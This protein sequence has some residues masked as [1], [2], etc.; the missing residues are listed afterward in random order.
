MVICVGICLQFDVS[1]TFNT[2]HSAHEKR[3]VGVKITGAYGLS[4]SVVSDIIAGLHPQS[5]RH[6][7]RK[8]SARGL[9]ALRPSQ[10]SHVTAAAT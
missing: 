6:F 4:L 7:A 1:H 2:W 8:S 10:L 3:G 5:P 9:L